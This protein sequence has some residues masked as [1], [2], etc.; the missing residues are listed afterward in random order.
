MGD[1]MNDTSRLA[2]LAAEQLELARA[3]SAGRAAVTL[4]G[5]HG[6]ALRQTLI[7]LRAGERL[8][9]H[10]NPGEATVQVL[11]G[12]VEVSDGGTPLSGRVGD[13]L[14]VPPLRHSL[15]AVEDAVVLLSAVP[16]GHIDPAST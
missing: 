8:E 3:A 16:R 14:V 4:Y 6:R 15:V 9:E 11:V 10:E 5:G 13:L 7:A 12:Q 2:D 1:T